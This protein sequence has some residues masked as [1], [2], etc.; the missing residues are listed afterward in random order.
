MPDFHA[1]PQ[2]Y[3]F[4]YLVFYVNIKKSCVFL[5]FFSRLANS[6]LSFFLF[7][8]PFVIYF[9]L[10]Y[11]DLFYYIGY[12]MLVLSALGGKKN[13]NHIITFLI[14]FCAAVDFYPGT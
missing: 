6:L 14:P 2:P 1:I 8:P 4:Y 12:Y 3:H 9:R 13:L 5:F 11:C 10:L 7:L